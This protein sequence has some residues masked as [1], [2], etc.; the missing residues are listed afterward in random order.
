MDI[1]E[2]LLLREGPELPRPNL[3]I[4]VLILPKYQPIEPLTAARNEE[5]SF[6]LIIEVHCDVLFELFEERLVDVLDNLKVL[7]L[8]NHQK[9]PGY[10]LRDGRLLSIVIDMLDS[11][12]FRLKEH[13][14]HEPTRDQ[15]GQGGDGKPRKRNVLFFVDLGERVMECCYYEDYRS[16]LA[17]VFDSRVR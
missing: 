16:H 10:L 2:D 8:F 7:V 13:P 3:E 17:Y 14:I 4:L 5:L 15:E 6:K 1:V 12:L 9:R 11:L